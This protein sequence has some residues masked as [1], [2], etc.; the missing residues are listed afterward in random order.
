MQIV[1]LT[2]PSVSSLRII[3]IYSKSFYRQ[4]KLITSYN[5]TFTVTNDAIAS[6][7]GSPQQFVLPYCTTGSVPR[8]LNTAGYFFNETWFPQNCEVHPFTVTEALT[9]LRNKTVYFYGD[10]T[11]RQLYE[12][13]VNRCWKTFQTK[14]I[15]T[16]KFWKVGPLKARDDVHNITLNYQHHGLPIRN[17]WTWVKD[18]RYV[19]KELD[20]LMEGSDVIVV[21]SLWAHFTAT[22]YGLFEQ[23]LRDIKYAIKE[24][25]NRSPQTTV[26]VKGANTRDHSGLSYALYASDWFAQHLEQI[27]RNAFAEDENIGYLDVWD[28][29]SAHHYKDAIH[30]PEEVV[31][32]VVN[33]MLTYICKVN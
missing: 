6:L 33:R 8:T 18:I 2:S 13:F 17:N 31:A 25:K 23:R 30:P 26:I 11:V 19:S 5:D 4:K 3:L 9:C 21:I 16:S 20:T 15:R 27:L 12:F 28:M 14:H 29:T 7:P 22:S 24:L 10:S 32:N 1:Q